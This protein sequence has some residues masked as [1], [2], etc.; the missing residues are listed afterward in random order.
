M[1]DIVEA[2]FSSVQEVF[3]SFF[4]FLVFEWTVDLAGLKLQTLPFLWWAAAETSVEVT[5]VLSELL[6]SV[7]TPAWFKVSLCRI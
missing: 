3:F 7:P 5:L 1:T 2:Q 4:W 6:W